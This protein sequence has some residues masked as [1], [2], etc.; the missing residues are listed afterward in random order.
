MSIIEK[1]IL[2]EGSKGKEEVPVLFDSGSTYS[3]IQKDLAKKLANYLDPLPQPIKFGTAKQ[4][5]KI[6]AEYAIRLYFYINSDRFSSEFIVL[7]ELSEKAIIGLLTL[8]SWRMKLDFEND[9]IL[10]DPKV[11][12]LRI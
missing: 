1:K 7:E 4:N 8:Q 11:T 9:Q 12:K 6:K 2:L 5:V 10:Y 3:C